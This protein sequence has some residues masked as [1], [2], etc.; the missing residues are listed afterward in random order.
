MRFRIFTI[1]SVV[2]IIGCSDFLEESSQDKVRPSTV[3]DLEQMFLGEAYVE[4]CTFY[5]CTWYFTDD[6]MSCGVKASS[7]QGDHDKNKWLFAWSDN[8]FTESGSGF[9]DVYYQTPYK[10]ILGCNLVL[11]YLDDMQ[12]EHQARENLRGEALALR[13]WYY[14]HLVNFFGVTYNQ[15]DPATEPGVPLKLDASVSGKYLNRN[16]VGEVYTRIEQDLLE[17]NRLLTAYDFNRNY[18]RVGHLA[19]KAILSRVYLY[20]EDWN[21]AI[22]YADSV[23]RVKSDLLDMNT[24]NWSGPDPMLSDDGVYNTSTP[25]EILWGRNVPSPYYFSWDFVRTPFLPSDEL[26]GTFEKGTFDDYSKGQTR[27]IR[28]ILNFAWTLDFSDFSYFRYGIYKVKGLLNDKYMQGIRTAE[29]YLN[30]AEAYARK[31]LEEGNVSYRTAALADLNELRRHRFNEAFAYEEVN[32]TDGEELLEFCLAERRRELCGETN[33]RWCDLRRFG[34]TVTHVLK[35]GSTS[36]EY[37]KDMSRYALPLQAE[38]LEWNPGLLQS[39]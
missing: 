23:L 37:V 15:C 31:Y 26:A 12:G 5:D 17:G 34:V 20:M 19:V 35:E 14:L 25:D 38:V 4:N 2:F 8:M 11:D 21:K 24:L 3:S 7:M 36:T 33:H 39:K 9:D 16:T 27:D 32:I 29:L 22:A 10:A 1:V 18:F 13:A 6:A 30:R 28:A